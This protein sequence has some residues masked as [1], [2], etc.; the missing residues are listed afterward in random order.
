M[1][2]LVVYTNSF[3]CPDM[4]RW[5]RWLD[6]HPVEHEVRDIAFDESAR[7]ELRRLVGTESVPTLVIT[8]DDSDDL[9]A[10]PE[11]L[12]GRRTRATDRGS[13]LSEPRGDQIAPFLLRHGIRVPGYEVEATPSSEATTAV[14][15]STR[16]DATHEVTVYP[17]AGPQLFFRIP[18]SFCRECDMTLHLVERVAEDFAD[19]R[20][21]V[22]PWLNHLVEALWRGGWHAP[23]VTI[24]GRVFSQ[25]VVPDERTFRARLNALTSNTGSIASSTTPTEATEATEAR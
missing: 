23:V 9:V 6:Q 18:D 7:C 22:K 25:G 3:P 8:E 20:V 10:P 5:A 17:I 12:G 16:R 13:M 11:P 21:T 4:F 19:V 2:R 15:P 24:D 14:A 1:A